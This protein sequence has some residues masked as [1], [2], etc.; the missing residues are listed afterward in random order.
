MGMIGRT[1]LHCTVTAELGAGA[2]GRVYLARDERTGR[3]VTLQFLPPETTGD[4]A[5]RARLLRE[6]TAVARLS[7]PAMRGPT[8]SRSARRSTS[9]TSPTPA[10]PAASARSPRTC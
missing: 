7:H 8:C 4:A 10:I 9:T 2:M 3:R 5:A 1:V 6:A